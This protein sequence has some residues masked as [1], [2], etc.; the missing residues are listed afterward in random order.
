MT[1]EEVIAKL[2]EGFVSIE[3]EKTDGT[4]RPM[5]A[6]LDEAVLPPAKPLAPGE[7]PKK[8]ADTALAV[9]DM[10]AAGWRSFR[11]DKL[12]FVDGVDLPNGI[13]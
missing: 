8:K 2:K 4:V 10:D 13:Q 1:R 3:F 6:T 12:R 9:W 5:V 7:T 11:W